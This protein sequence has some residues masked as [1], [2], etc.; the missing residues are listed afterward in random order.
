MS[1]CCSEDPCKG[2]FKCRLTKTGDIEIAIFQT[3]DGD[4]ITP[5][6]IYSEAS[7]PATTEFPDWDTL[8][9]EVN[10]CKEALNSSCCE[11]TEN[12]GIVTDWND[13]K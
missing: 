10:R 2:R 8:M 9:T 4:I 13:W 1:N 11:D 3:V 6:E 5:I 12:V 7:P